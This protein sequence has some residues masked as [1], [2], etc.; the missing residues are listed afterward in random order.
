VIEKIKTMKTEGKSA[1][2]IETKV[3]KESRLNPEMVAYIMTKEAP[4]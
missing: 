2:D 4:A 3:S 1:E